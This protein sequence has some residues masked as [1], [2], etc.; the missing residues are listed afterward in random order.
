MIDPRELRIGNYVLN[1]EFEPHVTI[2]SLEDGSED[3]YCKIGIDD[4]NFSYSSLEF[5]S[6]IP[7]T[8][9]WLDKFSFIPK[10]FGNGFKDWRTSEGF[11]VNEYSGMLSYKGIDLDSVHQLQNLFFAITGKELTIKT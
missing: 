7:L 9:E 2:L 3:N 1:E 11:T 8:E 6:Y 5:C 4:Y 10:D